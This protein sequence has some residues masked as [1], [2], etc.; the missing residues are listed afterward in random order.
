M[1][2]ILHS[3]TSELRS[4]LEKRGRTVAFATDEEVFA[5][6][7]KASVLPIVVSG[8]V[9]MMRYLEPGKELTIGIFR[10]GEMFALPPVF[11]GKNY[12]AT[13]VAMEKTVLLMVPRED[14][15]QLLRENSD[16]SFAVI[17]WM[18]NMLREKTAIIQN[19]ATSSPEHR[20]G[21]ILFR[22]AEEKIDAGPVRITL[23]RE[24]IAK[25]AG[26]TT[27]TTIRAVKKLADKDFF[28]IVHGK[29]VINSLEPLDRFLN[30]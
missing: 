6:G 28:S 25:M 12:P 10:N 19:L 1:K 29:V 4:K 20:I 24:D 16:L 5:E 2:P 17:G 15:L 3:L 26:L 11:D 9:R 8:S 30:A 27:E 7:D 21:T 14:F 13:A 23:R 22:L 18:C